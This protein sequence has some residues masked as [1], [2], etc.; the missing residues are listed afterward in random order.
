MEQEKLLISRN[1]KPGIDPSKTVKEHT[2]RNRQTKYREGYQEERFCAHVTN[3]N[4]LNETL[5]NL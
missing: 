1:R 5:R 2:T 3:P 4:D